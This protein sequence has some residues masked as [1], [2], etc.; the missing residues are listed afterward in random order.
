M[1]TLVH[2]HNLNNSTNNHNKHTL[3][4]VEIIDL[5]DYLSDD[6]VIISIHSSNNNN[7]HSDINTN[8]NN[9]S[10]DLDNSTVD[11]III[12]DSDNDD[13][14]VDLCAADNN[15]TTTQTSKC[16]H[17]GKL[18]D[19][20]NH[21]LCIACTELLSAINNQR[22]RKHKLNVTL[23][24]IDDMLEQDYKRNKLNSNN[25]INDTTTRNTKRNMNNVWDL[26]DSKQSYKPP[27]FDYNQHVNN[28]YNQHIHNHYTR[29][30]QQ[31]SQQTTSNNKQDAASRQQQ[32]FAAAAKRNA[33]RSSVN[34]LKPNNTSNTAEQLPIW[35]RDETIEEPYTTIERYDAI[36][37]ILTT[38][39]KLNPY[40]SLC[41]PIHNIHTNNNTEQLD[42]LISKHYRRIAKI[43][44]PDKNN[45]YKQLASDAF[46]ILQQSYHNLRHKHSK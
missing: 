36:Q 21:K 12:D 2:Q 24:Y 8:S 14:I 27:I 3:S 46:V 10:N 30:K 35:F 19:N 34:I 9:N 31:S 6:N 33:T 22:N 11:F 16:T 15:S 25:T 7:Q 38:N 44:H 41:L 1:S 37:Y 18:I 43:I 28:H 32:L 23:E 39:A 17:C 45:D 40:K 4:N 26:P 5:L 13:D 29:S 42:T 20:N